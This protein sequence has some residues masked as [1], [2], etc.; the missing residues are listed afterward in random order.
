MGSFSYCSR[1]WCSYSFL[2]E[3][4]STNLDQLEDY[5]DD[6]I[7]VGGNEIH[8]P[9]YLASRPEVG[10]EEFWGEKFENWRTNDSK[11][12]WDL[13]K[14][15]PSLVDV[16]PQL[17]ILKQRVA[18]MGAGAGHDAH[19]LSTLGHLVTAF[20]ISSEAIDKAKSLYPESDNLKYVQMDL[21]NPDE[22]QF[23]R[24]DLIFEHT[25]FCAIDPSQREQAIKSYRR[26]LDEE[27]HLLASLY[28]ITPEGGPPFG[29]T[30]WEIRQRLNG[31]FRNLYW[32]RWR[33]SVPQRDG[34]ELIYYGQKV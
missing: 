34:W 15:L 24:F 4:P 17:K 19:Y 29:S 14:P 3:S 20:D 21:L 2:Q 8:I 31:K 33:K 5:T 18:V 27:G 28:V 9:E 12:G 13:E 6:S 1:R 30:E 26:L 22:N 16:I 11:P 10:N 23:K 25:F 32:T 7:T